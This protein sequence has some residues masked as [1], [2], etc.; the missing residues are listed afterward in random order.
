[1]ISSATEKPQAGILRIVGIPALFPVGVVTLHVI[2]SQAWNAYDR[3]TWIDIP[4][5]LLGGVAIGYFFSAVLVRLQLAGVVAPLDV[6]VHCVLVFSLVAVAAVCWE[7]LEFLYDNAF[8]TNVQRNIANVMRDQ[9]V[10]VIGGAAIVAARV[11]TL[12]RVAREPGV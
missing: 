12:R 7:F 9:L 1:M 3:L 5:H 11:R 6:V 4:I 2:L 8:A 10:G